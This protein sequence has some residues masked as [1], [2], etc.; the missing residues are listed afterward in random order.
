MFNYFKRKKLQKAIDYHKIMRDS[1]F[2]ATGGLY[3]YC[4]VHEN[5]LGKRASAENRCVKRLEKLLEK[6]I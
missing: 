5:E 2:H 6:Y 1:L 4:E 3:Y